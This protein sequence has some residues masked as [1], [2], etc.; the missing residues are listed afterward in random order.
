MHRLHS[1]RS[2]GKVAEEAVAEERCHRCHKLRHCEQAGV[3]SLVTVHLA[4]FPV[5]DDSAVDAALEQRMDIAQRLTSLVLSLR[6]KANIK[7]RQPLAKILVPASDS[8]T[9]EV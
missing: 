6:K 8:V 7:V 5:C 2:R 4:D 1:F 9:A 3:K